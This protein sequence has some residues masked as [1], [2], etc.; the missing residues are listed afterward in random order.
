MYRFVSLITLLACTGESVIE[1]QQNIAPSINIVSHS[2]GASLQEGYIESFRAQVSDDDDAFEDL[3]VAWYVGDDIVCDWDTPSP[4]GDAFC[5]VVFV[6][7]DTSII[8]TVRDAQGA[9]AM[10]EISVT[11]SPTEAPTAVI[12]APE[13]GAVHADPM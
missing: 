3:Q 8:A 12:L 6:P 4:A 2:D 9:G 11:V 1:K 13:A 5:D 10:D 7:D